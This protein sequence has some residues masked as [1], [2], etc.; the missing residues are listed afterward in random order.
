MDSETFRHLIFGHPDIFTPPFLTPR[1]FDNKTF[2]HPD[3]VPPRYC[4]NQTLCHCI[5]IKKFLHP[6][7]LQPRHFATPVILTTRHLQPK[8]YPTPPSILTFVTWIQRTQAWPSAI[9]SHRLAFSQTKSYSVQP[10]LPLAATIG[11]AGRSR[12]FFY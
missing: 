9:S 4:A 3:I 1:H 7:I 6:D 12:V 10:R 8:L 5:Q 11:P 2:C